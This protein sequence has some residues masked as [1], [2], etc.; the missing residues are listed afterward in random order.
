[1][2]ENYKITNKIGE[3]D[4]SK[5]YNISYDSGEKRVL[6]VIDYSKLNETLKN[7]VFNELKIID[8]INEQPNIVKYY[9]Y[10]INDQ[11]KN[12][13]VGKKLNPYATNTIIYDHESEIWIA[14]NNVFS[15]NSA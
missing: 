3:T 1:M 14:G 4:I 6:K 10:E 2:M 12:I 11:T 15:K 9:N 7:R 5:V 13:V 8:I